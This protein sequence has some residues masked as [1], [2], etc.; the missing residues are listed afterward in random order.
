MFLGENKKI[1]K[2]IGIGILLFFFIFSVLG[3]FN[4]VESAEPV[5]RNRNVE[6]AGEFERGGIVNAHQKKS[7]NQE[8]SQAEIEKLLEERDAALNEIREVR[9]ESNRCYPG[10]SGTRISDESCEELS[11][12]LT[13][14]ASL[15]TQANQKNDE[16]RRIASRNESLWE[17]Y[18]GAFNDFYNNPSEGG[19][20]VLEV[21]CWLEKA[22]ENFLG[23]IANFFIGASGMVLWFSGIVLNAAVFFSIE[24]MSNLINGEGGE[25]IRNAWTMIRDLIN[26]LF[27][28]GLLYISIGTI[29]GRLSGK[30]KNMLVGIIA[31]AILI[32]FSFLFTTVLIDVSN[33]LTVEMKNLLGECSQIGAGPETSQGAGAG[34]TGGSIKESLNKSNYNKGI[35]NCFV[36]SV[37]IQT[38]FNPETEGGIAN[39]VNASQSTTG[40]VIKILIGGIMGSVFLILTAVVFLALAILLF[41]RFILLIFLIITSPAMFLGMILPNFTEISKTWFKTLQ[42]QLIWAPL[43]FLF[44]FIS[45][46]IARSMSLVGSSG[47]L[48]GTV[49]GGAENISVIIN[50]LLVIGFMLASILIA[51]KTGA[52]GADWSTQKA[53]NVVFGGLGKI[54]RNTVGRA[55]SRAAENMKGTGMVSRLSKAGLKNI[56][57]ST[58][59]ARN[60]TAVSAGFSGIGKATGVNIDTGKGSKSGFTKLNQEKV[61]KYKEEAKEFGELS[62]SEKIKITENRGKINTK[63]ENEL[64]GIKNAQGRVTNSENSLKSIK[65]QM[66][67]AKK[68]DRAEY[69]RL[70]VEK[71]RFEEGIDRDKEFIKQQKAVIENDELSKEI[72]D[73]EKKAEKRQEDFLNNVLSKVY[74]PAGRDARREI[75]EE[76]EKKKK[77]G[78]VEKITQEVIAGI[79]KDDDK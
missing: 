29:I 44:L 68:T 63:Y 33:Y 20:G 17:W 55:A 9:Q 19:C 39:V 54:G 41:I 53:G 77:Q 1:N 2:K 79:K 76:K 7:S 32:N 74:R 30:T 12:Y 72:R 46:T 50:Y 67:K 62:R 42:N 73:T 15:R 22:T 43:A 25:G 60:S 51:K 6:G 64:S 78:S 23:L 71:E 57:N 24:Q 56:G 4:F 37:K 58:F 48:S 52:A 26:I 59:D 70:S 35:S 31:A 16:A 45:L 21:G 65:K 40:K 5:T 27:I 47:D 36:D 8:V 11:Y 34:T 61:K 14:V 38:A 28:F 13:K 18:V 10:G 49:A 66:K 3:D 75:L 69:D